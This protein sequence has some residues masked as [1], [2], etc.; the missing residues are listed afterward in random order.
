[1]ASDFEERG[2][3][4]LT[5]LSRYSYGRA[6]ENLKEIMDKQESPSEHM[7]LG[8]TSAPT[9]LVAKYDNR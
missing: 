9:S 7:S 1:M 8:L 2:T 4:L 5:E 3:G 6:V